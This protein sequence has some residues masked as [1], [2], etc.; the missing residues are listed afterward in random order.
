MVKSMTGYGRCENEAEGR[1]FSVEIKSVNHRYNDIS[2]RLP[3]TMNYLED[4][5]RKTWLTV[6]KSGIKICV[7]T[8]LAGKAYYYPS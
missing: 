3:R 2:I 8:G 4:K 5:I 1:K 7:C 6:P